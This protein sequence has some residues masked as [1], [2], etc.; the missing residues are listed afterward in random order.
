MVW[1][2]DIDVI[3]PKDSFKSA[4][5]LINDGCDFV[6]PY[7]CGVYQY[8]VNYP[9]DLFQKFIQSEYNLSLLR[10]SSSRLP[11]TV[12]FSQ[13][14]NRESYVDFGMM[15]ENFMSW[16]CEDVELYYRMSCLEYKI[17]RVWSDVYHLEHSRTFN[18]HYNNPSF[19][20]NN[21]LWEWFR[22]QDKKTIRDYYNQQEYYKKRTS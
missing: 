21:N 17:G 14:F 2:Y 10:D 3:F 16:G 20:N 11:C 5:D 13:V 18:S 22:K 19:N 12:G 8:A 9:Q 4:F 15:N 1:H 6:Y 7:G